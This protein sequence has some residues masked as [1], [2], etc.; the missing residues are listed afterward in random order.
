MSTKEIDPWD[1]ARPGFTRGSLAA[2]ERQ[3]IEQE[4]ATYV[5]EAL[6]M[7]NDGKEATV[8]LCRVRAGSCEAEYLA[9]KMYRARKFRAF[10]TDA[11]YVNV[12]RVRDK[13]LAKAMRQ[14]SRHGR[15]AAH[16]Q[17]I[18]REWQMLEMLHAAGA[19]VPQPYMHC[20]VG[21]LMEYIGVAEQRAPA[22][23]ELRLTKEE[24]QQAFEAVVRDLEILLECGVIHGDLSAYNILYIDNTPRMIDLPQAMRIDDAADPWTL[25]HRDVANICDYFGKRG[26]EVDALDLALRL[27]R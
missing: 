10:T 2:A 5:A 18:D 22:L 11:K 4:F 25:F 15:D 8:Y 13:R 16:Y 20:S 6:G 27:W 7:V 24:A 14:K 21:I 26:I 1:L 23:A 12:D 17:W 9:A 19:S 3:V